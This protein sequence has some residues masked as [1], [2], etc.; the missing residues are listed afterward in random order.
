V[1]TTPHNNFLDASDAFRG[2]KAGVKTAIKVLKDVHSDLLEKN[3]KAYFAKMK[4]KYPHAVLTSEFIE[5]TIHAIMVVKWVNTNGGYVTPDKIAIGAQRTGQQVA[6]EEEV[7]RTIVG[8]EDSTVN[9]EKIIR[10]CTTDIPNEEMDKIFLNANELIDETRRQG[11]CPDNLMDT[12]DIFKLPDGQN[13]YRD[14]R[15]F[16]KSSCCVVNCEDTINRKMVDD[17]RRK[18]LP[19]NYTEAQKVVLAGDRALE[20]KNIAM[21]KR[22]LEKQR[23]TSM[24][25]AERKTEDAAKKA[26]KAKKTLEKETTL[27]EARALTLLPLR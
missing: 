14:N 21:E 3:L 8:C 12:L 6:S 7:E 1:S 16:F 4:V 2:L 17:V 24:T 23:R 9:T 19:T 27:A 25:D 18:P 15:S 5:K 26:E 20:Q 22:L 11:R 10:L 13:Q